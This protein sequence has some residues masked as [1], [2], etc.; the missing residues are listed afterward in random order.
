MAKHYVY[1]TLA[2]AV[3]YQLTKPGPNDL[4]MVVGE[5]LVQGGAG[6]VPAK[7]E[8]G[9]NPAPAGVATPITEAQKALLEANPVFQIHAQNGY[10]LITTDA[11]DP[12]R[13]AA[14]MNTGDKSKQL[15]EA[16]FPDGQAVS[17]NKSK[18]KK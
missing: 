2:A 8:P 17:V 7:G 15:S 13:M 16:D 9:E 3:R 18:A 1:S 4:P 6:V 14:D 12:E 5:V 11:P 10:V